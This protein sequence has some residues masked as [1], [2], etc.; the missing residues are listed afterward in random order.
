MDKEN[1][2]ESIVMDVEETKDKTPYVS[3]EE[4]SAYLNEIS[5]VLT[6]IAKGIS[7]SLDNMEQ[8]VKQGDTDNG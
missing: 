3:C 2:E 4:V 7:M 1:T 6:D 8:F 5:K